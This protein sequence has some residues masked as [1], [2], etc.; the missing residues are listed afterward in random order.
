MP[1]RST[2]PLVLLG[3]VAV[4]AL[5]R[6]LD[7]QQ[8]WAALPVPG[9]RVEHALVVYLLMTLIP[10]AF[11]RVRLWVPAVALIG[12]GVGVELIQEL[13]GVVGRAQLGDVAADVA[14]VLL[15]LFP[16]WMARH[17]CEE[18]PRAG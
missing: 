4:Y 3:L 15:G 7:P 14:G 17:R 13:P 1:R 18:N 11:P 6:L 5:A 2:L 9:D 10:A 16:M 12:L 8:R